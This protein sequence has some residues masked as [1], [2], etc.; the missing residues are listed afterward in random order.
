MKSLRGSEKPRLS[1]CLPARASSSGAPAPRDRGRPFA[2]PLVLSHDS[3]LSLQSSGPKRV[4]DGCNRGVEVVVLRHGD[5]GFV[6]AR[7]LVVEQVL[8]QNVVEHVVSV[9]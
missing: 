8:L 9:A 6:V 4:S 5:V 7:R 2:K 1:A 3:G